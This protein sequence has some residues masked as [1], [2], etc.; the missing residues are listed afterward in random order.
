MM[1]EARGEIPRAYSATAV[2]KNC[3]EGDAQPWLPVDMISQS[4]LMSLFQSKQQ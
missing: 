2:I 4:I 3:P 1:R